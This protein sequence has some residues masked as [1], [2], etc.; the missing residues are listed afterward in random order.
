MLCLLSPYC[1]IARQPTLQ[2]ITQVAK[3]HANKVEIISPLAGNQQAANV[4]GGLPEILFTLMDL[5]N[6]RFTTQAGLRNLGY[7]V[8]RRKT[9]ARPSATSPMYPAN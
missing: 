9:P 8:M 6:R 7:A 2:V 5:A 4:D 3:V 1:E